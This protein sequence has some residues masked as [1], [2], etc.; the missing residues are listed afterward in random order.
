MNREVTERGT[1]LVYTTSWCGDCHRIKFML[2]EYGIRYIEVD[3][4]KNPEAAAEVKQINNGM[5][6]VP[7]IIFPD[8]S[9]LVEPNSQVLLEKLGLAWEKSEK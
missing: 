6:R 9:V 7:T 3:I 8:D 2:H 1:L 5:R 4:D